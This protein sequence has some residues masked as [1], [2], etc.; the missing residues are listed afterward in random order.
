MSKEK[1]IEEMIT[2]ISEMQNGGWE[3]VGDSE[4]TTDVSNEALAEHLYNAG[5]RKQSEGE[6]VKTQFVART[7][8]YT[9]KEFPCNQC[10]EKFEVA[11]GNGLMHFCPNCGAKMK[12][13]GEK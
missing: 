4:Y 8:F 13:G 3:F 9:I 12:G 10:G 11:K 6:W 2:D 7:G 5:Y 1:Q